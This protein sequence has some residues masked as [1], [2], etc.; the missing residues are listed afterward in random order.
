L[1]FSIFQSPLARC[2]GGGGNW[3]PSWVSFRTTY[4]LHPHS[5]EVSAD[6]M[7]SSPVALPGY[8]G[9]RGGLSSIEM[10]IGHRYL[11]FVKNKFRD[12]GSWFRLLA[13]HHCALQSPLARCAGTL[14]TST[15][16]KAPSQTWCFEICGG[17]GN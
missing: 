5:L 11:F 3:S 1:I 10:G 16:F 13:K 7:F 15:N 12:P 2:A 17:G 8:A 6:T 9:L 14:L 4:S